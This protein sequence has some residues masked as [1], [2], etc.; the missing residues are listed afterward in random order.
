MFL[1]I[2]CCVHRK[3]LCTLILSFLMVNSYLGF[4]GGSVVKDPPASTGDIRTL[5]SIPR[6]GRSPGGGHGNP[7]Q[8]FC[9]EN[10]MDRGA[11]WA[12]VHGVAKSQSDCSNLAR[13]DRDIYLSLWNHSSTRNLCAWLPWRFNGWDSV[14]PVQGARVWTLVRELDATCHN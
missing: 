12:T 14:L 10:P 2:L 5:C 6:S 1:L 4:S 9:L 8:Y 11:W 3:R 7:L 13:I